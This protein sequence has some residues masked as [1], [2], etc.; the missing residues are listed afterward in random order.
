MK[1]ESM[2]A[3]PSVEKSAQETAR[4]IQQSRFCVAMTGAGISTNAGI[5]DFRGPRGLYVTRQYDADKIFDIAYFYRDQKPFF[6]FARDFVSLEE[7]VR[8]TPTHRFLQKLEEAGIL[9]AVITQNIDAL[10]QKAGSRNVLEVHGSIW[11][12]H[13]L[14]C[15]REFSYAQAKEKVLNETVPRCSCGGVIKPDI[16]FFGENVKS[17]DEASELARRADLFFVIGT[18]CVVYPA[19]MLPTLTNGKIIVANM[20]EVDIPDANI[21]VSIHEDLDVF[22][23]KVAHHLNLSLE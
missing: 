8:P 13:C 18:S 9:K 2:R 20:S 22:F 3:R 7:R 12:S 1:G 16:V 17:F 21:A 19:A 5:P 6:E 14:D 15:G 23:E 10:H 4:L 11:K